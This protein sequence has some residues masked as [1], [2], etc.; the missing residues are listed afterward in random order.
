MSLAVVHSRASRGIDAPLVTVEVHISKGIPSL[1]IVGLPETVVK[2]SRHRVRSAIMNSGL[3][4]PL[5]RITV[6]LAPADLPKEGGRFDLAIALGI[7]TA[8][9]QLPKNACEGYEFA[10]ELALSGA[11]RSIQGALPFAIT[12]AKHQRRLIIAAENK[13][14]VALQANNHCCIANHLLEVVAHLNNT[15]QLEQVQYHHMECKQPVVDISTVCG[16][17]CGKRALEI[18]AAGGH[19]CLFVGPPGTGKTLLSSC[20]SGILPPLSLE[21][22]LDVASIHSISH[23]GFNV[24][25]WKQRPFR[26]PHHSAS[27]P[28]MVGGSN[29]PKPG[30]ISLAHHGV[31]FLDE[32]PEFSRTVLESLREP[33]ESKIAT[34]SRA[35]HQISF[36]ANFQLLTAMNPC[37]CG[38]FGDASGR[39]RCTE[40]QVQRYRNRLSG[41]LLD[42]IDMHVEMPWQDIA[43]LSRIDKNAE[44]SQVVRQRV[45][46]ARDLQQ[47]RSEKINAHYSITDIEQCCDIS[48]SEQQFLQRAIQHYQLSNRVY[49]RI[50]KLARTIAD[51]AESTK[52]LQPH[53]AEALSFRAFD[54][55]KVNSVL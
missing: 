51:L 27:A 34:I 26:S 31:L 10:G 21:Q 7:L 8:S 9:H 55:A 35:G 17:A 50:L 24:Q 6:N 48:P 20:L 41:P 40:D 36:P 15:S 13:A 53:I 16:Q 33:L 52:I 32:L 43:T 46:R 2:E 39:C 44:N 28:A 1:S 5:G 22:A 42:R 23:Q 3:E 19:S 18:A 54:H 37:P 30:E 25:H 12:T 14:E 4:F 47:Q 49:H 45:I 29:P 38:Y 11:L